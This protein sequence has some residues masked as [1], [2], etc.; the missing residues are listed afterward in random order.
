MH[1]QNYIK[2]ESYL[3]IDIIIINIMKVQALKFLS[4]LSI[5]PNRLQFRSVYISTLFYSAVT[6]FMKIV[7]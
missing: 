3:I 2:E 7:Q 4:L 1:C 6:I 5:F